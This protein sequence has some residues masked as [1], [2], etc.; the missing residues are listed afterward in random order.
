[1]KYEE[2]NMVPIKLWCFLFG[3][4]FRTMDDVFKQGGCMVVT[5]PSNWCRNCGLT[6]KEVGI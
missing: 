1:M 6:K 3:H 2:V 5:K 4:D